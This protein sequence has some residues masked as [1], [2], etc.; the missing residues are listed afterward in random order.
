M[1]GC[2]SC[3]TADLIAAGRYKHIPWEEVPCATC[4]TMTGMSHAIEYDDERIPTDE[5]EEIYHKPEDE[6]PEFVSLDVM[7]DAMVAFLSLRPDVRDVIAWR[8]A[9]LKYPDIASLQGV[10]TACVEKR[11]RTAMLSWP[12]LQ[13]L[14]PRKIAKQRMRK[15][16]TRR[17]QECGNDG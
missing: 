1:T 4:A 11:H 8:L 9:G 14:F 16:H 15:P 3:E 10:T 17:S 13:A 7:I 12:A 5:A 2:H 6:E